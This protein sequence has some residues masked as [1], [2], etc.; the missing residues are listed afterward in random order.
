MIR[1]LVIGLLVIAVY[2][3]TPVGVVTVGAFAAAA[4]DAYCEAISESGK[5]ALRDRV[6]AGTQVIACSA[7]E[8][9]R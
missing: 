6:T 1:I 5:Q 7:S 2:G 8:V 3:C 4:V 9:S